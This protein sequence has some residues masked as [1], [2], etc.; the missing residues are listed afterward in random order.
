MRIRH[1]IEEFND[2]LERI[3]RHVFNIRHQY[4][5]IRSLKQN[6]GADKALIHMDFSENFSCQYHQ[7]VQSVHFGSSHNQATLHTVM[8][9]TSA[10]STPICTISDSVRKDPAAIW[11]HL[12]PILMFIKETFPEIKSLH[13]LSDGPSTQYKNRTN[14]AMFSKKIYDMGFM[15]ASWNFLETSHGKGAPDGIGAVIKRTAD[16]LI[17]EK[18]DIP[19]SR[20]LFENLNTITSIKL[21]FINSDDIIDEPLYN[22]IVAVKGTL[23]I[24]QLITTKFGEILF[25]DVSCFCQGVHCDCYQ[26]SRIQILKSPDEIGEHTAETNDSPSKDNSN[27]DTNKDD[28]VVSPELVGQ[29]CV[30]EYEGKF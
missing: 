16:R 27:S 8:L 14:F 15:E 13:F 26:P 17:S 19:N 10:G 5:Q 28:I 25:R 2:G 12:N 6:L 18:T 30:V 3:C 21:F 9:Y 20:I 4:S 11:C 22:D 24:H 7:E 1:L 23:K 29:L